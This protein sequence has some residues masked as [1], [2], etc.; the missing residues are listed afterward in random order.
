M[1]IKTTPVSR[2][3]EKKM[4]VMGF[5]VP[6]LL[7]IFLLLSVLNFLFGSTDLKIPLVWIP[8]L[9]VAGIIRFVKR[10]KPENYLLHWIRYQ[11]RP[12]ILSAFVE[13]SH[14]EFRKAQ[15]RNR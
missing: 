12:G 4:I 6:D 7:M 13:P 2:C 5:E 8:S 15:R 9:A 14:N 3:L 10:G 1:S 11:M